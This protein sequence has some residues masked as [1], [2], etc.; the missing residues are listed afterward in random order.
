[1]S[2]VFVAALLGAGLSGCIDTDAAVFVDA[3]IV[4]AS[5][6]VESSSLVTAL[7]GSFTLQLHLGPRANDA[8]EVK[9]NAVSVTN[10]DRTVTLVD[11]LGALPSQPF[12]LTVGIDSDVSVTF[13]APADENQLEA[14][15]AAEICGAGGLVFVVV[16]DDSLR[17]GSITPASDAVVPAGCP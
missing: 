17:G 10:P 1:M 3:T 11:A 9:L 2:R 4:D 6:T 12:P 5:A 14:A 7:S 13:S 16:L 8:A 15:K